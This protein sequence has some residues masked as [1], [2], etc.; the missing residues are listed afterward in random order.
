MIKKTAVILTAV[1]VL[2]RAVPMYAAG[3]YYSRDDYPKVTAEELVYKK[4]D[5][6]VMKSNLSEIK[7][8]AVNFGNGEKI[9]NLTDECFETCKSARNAY[10]MAMLEYDGNFCAEN[11]ADFAE[12]SDLVVMCEE[13][14]SE[15]IYCLYGGKYEYI[16]ADIFGDTETAL[17]YA[18]PD[19]DGIAE[20]LDD[21]RELRNEYSKNTDNPEKC[22]DIFVKLLAV[23]NKIANLF[24]YDDYSEYANYAVYGRD[25]TDEDMAAFNAAVLRDIVPLYENSMAAL[26]LL[27]SEEMPMSEDDLLLNAR[28]VIRG[29]NPELA[30]SFEYMIANNLYDLKIGD[31]KNPSVG[32]YT[33]LLPTLNVPYIFT[34]PEDYERDGTYTFTTLIHE[35]GHF[36]SMLNTPDT[37]NRYG[38][39]LYSANI[40]TAEIHSQGLEVLAE[41]FYGRMFGANAP[42]MRYYLL[43]S[44]TGTIIDGCLMNEWQE[45]VYSMH[46]PT[47]EELNVSFAK[48]AE[49]YYGAECTPENAMEIWTA[50]P[51]NFQMPMYYVSYA[52]SGTAALGIYSE[53]S[54]N[55]DK[56]TDTYMRISAKGIYKT[57]SEI[58]DEC[59]L[60][61]VF[62]GASIGTVADDLKKVYGFGY[63][64][65]TGEEWYAPYLFT[66]SNIMHARTENQFM[67]ETPVT[68]A[69]FIGTV[70]RMYEYYTGK[71]MDFESKFKDIADDENTKYIAW[72]EKTGVVSGYDDETFGPNDTLTRE[73]AVTVLYRLVGAPDIGGC[74]AVFDDSESISEWA[75]DAVTWAVHAE[76]VNGKDD[77]MFE[78]LDRLT[79][80]E[81]AKITA[82]MIIELY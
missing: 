38:S 13:Y 19:D 14:L 71:K 70:G 34:N 8:L 35:F 37:G 62:D 3:T 79:R 46:E 67:P 31:G 77:D 82:C 56:A 43:A 40:D 29:I 28:A 55:Y 63:D 60:Y 2:L 9:L 16:L 27:P 64:D 59:G 44:L 58:C 75:R 12:A 68:R 53:A 49:K 42:N 36:A 80:A 23:R 52:L 20:L 41:K 10:V 30:D 17:A 24:G 6:S 22:A 69:E 7:K 74:D 4:S 15:L 33:I 47:V 32:A 54:R 50:V 61:D 21:E 39:L 57:F 72:A 48:L 1:T 25:Y 81:T 65:V 5:I 76:I 78:P 18:L 26:W 51:H 45:E 73:Q 66:V 11:E